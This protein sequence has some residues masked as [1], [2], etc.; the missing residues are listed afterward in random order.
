MTET[1]DELRQA[2][3]DF[4]R[5]C[6]ALDQAIEATKG[7]M[8]VA[9]RRAMQEEVAPHLRRRANA[10]RRLRDLLEDGCELALQGWLDQ[11][12]LVATGHHRDAVDRLKPKAQAWVDMAFN[13]GWLAARNASVGEIV[14]LRRQVGQAEKKARSQAEKLERLEPME[15]RRGF[16]GADALLDEAEAV[17]KR[18]ISQEEMLERFRQVG[19][20]PDDRGAEKAKTDPNEFERVGNQDYARYTAKM[21]DAHFSAN[22]A[23]SAPRVRATEGWQPGAKCAYHGIADCLNCREMGPDKWAKPEKPARPREIAEAEAKLFCPDCGE[24][25]M[26]GMPCSEDT[27]AE[28]AEAVVE[29]ALTAIR[30][31]SLGDITRAIVILAE[32]EGDGSVSTHLRTATN[33]QLETL[34][35]LAAALDDAQLFS[36]Y[37]SGEAKE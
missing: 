1:N 19:K 14:K 9:R 12:H 3:E 34:G 7:P 28:N 31:G 26:S 27:D 15:F 24:R 18:P 37:K 17:L 16:D 30:S 11:R 5:C 22:P 35:L 33:N 4:D 32:V 20:V 8:T 13:A 6:R 23:E 10:E 29:Q 36:P 21:L 25:H 2:Y